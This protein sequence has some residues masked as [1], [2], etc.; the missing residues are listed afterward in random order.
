M[1]KSREKKNKKFCPAG[2]PTPEDAFYFV[3]KP[4]K[5]KYI[6]ERAEEEFEK[7]NITKRCYDAMMRYEV[8]ITD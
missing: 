8:E 1:S 5:E 6:K 7:G 2:Y 4:F 3:Y